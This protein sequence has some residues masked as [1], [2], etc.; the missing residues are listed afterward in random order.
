MFQL[1]YFHILSEVNPILIISSVKCSMI[2]ERI[3]SAL[4]ASSSDLT[5]APNNLFRFPALNDSGD[6]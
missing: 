4:S 3:Y 2:F 6:I 1:T 5:R